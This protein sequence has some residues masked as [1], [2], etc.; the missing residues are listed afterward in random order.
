MNS[1]ANDKE[2][3]IFNTNT[4]DGQINEKYSR[5]QE[6]AYACYGCEKIQG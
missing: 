5:D 2:T 1:V 4:V 3:S 6:G